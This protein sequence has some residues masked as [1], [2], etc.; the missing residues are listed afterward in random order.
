MQ[1]WTWSSRGFIGARARRTVEK[2]ERRSR[3]RRRR[4]RRDVESVELA[5]VKRN[6]GAYDE[7][8]KNNV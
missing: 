5:Y 3:R 8:R 2:G 7:R 6:S 4:R 1:R